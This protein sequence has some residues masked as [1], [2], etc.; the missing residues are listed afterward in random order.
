MRFIRKFFFLAAVLTVFT[1]VYSSA[2][3]DKTEFLNTLQQLKE[4]GSIP[5]S[6]GQITSYGDF[7]DSYTNMGTAKY[8]TI[9]EADHFVLSSK[10]SW[11]SAFSAPNGAVSGCGFIFGAGSDA[12]NYL[13]TSIRM[14]GYIYFNGFNNGNRLSY[15]QQF[16]TTPSIQGEGFLT[17]VVDGSSVSIYFNG[18]QISNR[19][20]VVIPGDNLGFAILSGTNKDFGTQCTFEDIFLYTWQDEIQ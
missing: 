1:S 18:N 15:G 17:L 13:M 2:F 5:V 19:N 6:E 20:D 8:Y 16:V 10:I 4:N 12:S 7:S 11:L 9:T 3:A 14:N